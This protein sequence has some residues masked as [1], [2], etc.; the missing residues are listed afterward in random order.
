MQ[1][2]K[3]FFLAYSFGD[4]EGL[5]RRL[6]DLAKQGWELTG[7]RG[8]L[9]GT[10]QPTRRTELYY[11]VVPAQPRRSSQQLEETARRREGEGWEAVDTVWGMDIYKSLPLQ[12]PE[13]RRDKDACQEMR[14]VF[15]FWLQNAIANL[16]VTAALL[17]LNREKLNWDRLTDRWYLSD[18]KMAA[19]VLLP[20]LA[21][22]CLWMLVWLVFCLLRRAAPH[23]PPH[24]AAMVLRA[25][26]QL[27]GLAALALLLAALW[28]DPVPRLWIR[29]VLLVL[30]VMI[31]PMAA[32]MGR[33]G[34]QAWLLTAGGGVFALFAL[35]MVLSWVVKPVEYDLQTPVLPAEV[36]TDEPEGRCSGWYSETESLLVRQCDCYQRW[37]DGTAAEITLY[38]CRLSAVANLVAGD[39]SSLGEEQKL[40][41]GNTVCIASGFVELNEENLRSILTRFDTMD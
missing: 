11:D 22:V 39:V 8:W 37:E 21:A 18:S 31:L 36:L 27:G 7:R 5:R 28:V 20:M 13:V 9:H 2:S 29:L 14:R 6:D 41:V 40:L 19:L 38:Q 3:R 33:R 15:G 12:M 1:E 24:P 10:F 26:L 25:G 17:W 35:T 16:V 23:H 4:Y 30:F 32:L 34:R